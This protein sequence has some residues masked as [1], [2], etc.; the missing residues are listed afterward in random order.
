[1]K[2]N[3]QFQVFFR[4][5]RI[6]GKHPIPEANSRI[7][8]RSLL[9]SFEPHEV[10]VI[11]DN[12]SPEQQNYFMQQASCCYLTKLGNCGSFRLQ[13]KLATHVHTAD[14]YYFCEDDHLHLP[15]QKQW[16]IAG[17]KHFDF[18]SLYDHPDKY[19]Q[20]NEHGLMRKVLATPVGH[21]AGTPSTVMTFAIKRA[22]LLKCIDF[23]TKSEH[24]NPKHSFPRDHQL[25]T[26]LTQQG[27]TI[28]TCLPGRSTH[29]EREGLSPY[30]DWRSYAKSIHQELTKNA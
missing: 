9:K 26:E 19:A 30:T 23:L 14:I 8:Y 15:E 3:E 28:G 24:T 6:F 5:S 1:M 18:V 12:A 29:C 13:I 22:T 16:L 7:T 17:L 21:F 20:W 25:F 11:A 27:F 2:D 4:T 10:A